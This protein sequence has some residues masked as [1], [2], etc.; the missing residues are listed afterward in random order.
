M[1]SNARTRYPKL[2]AFILA[3]FLAMIGGNVPASAQF[4]LPKLPK[5]SKATKKN[6][7]KTSEN[8]SNAPAPQ[9][10]SISPSSAP[11]GGAGEVV[12]VGQNL[13]PGMRLSISCEGGSIQSKGFKVESAER[14]VVQITVPFGTGEGP[15]SLELVRFAGGASGSGETE[16]SPRGTPEMFQIPSSGPTFSISSTGKMPVSLPVVLLG[17]GDMDFMQLMTKMQAA[18]KPAF[19]ETGEKTVLQLSP[20]SVKYLRGSSTLFAE[21]P[22]AVKAVQ[23]MNMQGQSTGI[24]RIVFNNGKIYNFMG[25][26]GESQTGIKDLGQFVKK[27]LGK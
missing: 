24:F 10:T 13:T 22:S 12:L 20:D 16:E 27:K 21:S 1:H 5:L 2:V 14:A 26:S 19:G 9:L 17:E 11:P 4:G 6:E 25:G 7:K 15:C 23:S 8:P 18:M 3:A